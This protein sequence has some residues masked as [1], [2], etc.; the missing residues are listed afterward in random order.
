[1]IKGIEFIKLGQNYNDR[2][3]RLL[4]NIG[5]I[6]SQKIGRADEHV[7]FRKMFKEDDDY[8]GG[9]RTGEDRDNWLVGKSWY[10]KAEDMVD[11]MDVPIRGDSP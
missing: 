11:T 10:Q 5:W 1:M 7:Q 2:E 8:H 6:I 3:P 4:S 9:D